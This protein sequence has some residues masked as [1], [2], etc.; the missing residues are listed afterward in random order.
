MFEPVLSNPARLI[1]PLIVSAD[2]VVNLL[3]LS[4]GAAPLDLFEV[5]TEVRREGRM[6]E[7]PLEMAR[8]SRISVG[9]FV[10]NPRD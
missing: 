3:V 9:E 10:A 1:L 4:P 8:R 2:L 5:I 7:E 6:C